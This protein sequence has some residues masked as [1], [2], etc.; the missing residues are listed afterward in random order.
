MPTDSREPS[1]GRSGPEAPPPWPSPT[2]PSTSASA[3]RSSGRGLLAGGRAGPTRLHAAAAD[4]V[5]ACVRFA[6]RLAVPAHLSADPGDLLQPRRALRRCGD[7]RSAHRDHHRH[8]LRTPGGRRV[9]SREL[10]QAVRLAHLAELDAVAGQL[11]QPRT[12]RLAGTGVGRCPGRTRDGDGTGGEQE[13][14][15]F[16]EDTP[17]VDLEARTIIAVMAALEKLLVTGPPGG[18]RWLQRRQYT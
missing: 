12:F 18:P 5:V 6:G 10:L 9:P 14:T 11:H 15:S 2:G 16:H 4:I 8:R 1:A 13:V 7:Q 17:L 3:L